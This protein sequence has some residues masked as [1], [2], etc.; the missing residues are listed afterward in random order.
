M[1][2]CLIYHMRLGDIIQCFP[3]AKRLQE[4][5]HEVLIECNPEYHAIFY[6]INYAKPVAPGGHIEADHFI[7]LSIWPNDY[8]AYRDSRLTWREWVHGK[9]F[10][11]C[12]DKGICDPAP[13]KGIEFDNYGTR[14]GYGLPKRYNLVSPFGFSQVKRYDPGILGAFA[15][16]C[17]PTAPT[18]YL[19][20]PQI[21]D[22]PAPTVTVNHLP[23]LLPIIQDAEVFVTINSAPTYIASAVRDK[24]AHVRQA[25]FNYQD[26]FSHKSQ[27][28]LEWSNLL[29]WAQQLT[30]ARD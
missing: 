2:L 13:I 1:K 18:Y 9:F 12:Q 26:D 16:K 27:T 25:D 8:Q 4:L 5:G 11:W 15:N 22:L 17:N 20:P 23:D 19:V 30:H 28:V 14:A 7:D 6:T 29:T 24:Y 21:R 10:T 3:M